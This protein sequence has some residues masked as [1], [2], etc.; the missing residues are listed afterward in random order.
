MLRQ[1]FQ[2]VLVITFDL[3]LC[4][5]LLLPFAAFLGIIAVRAIDPS[6]VDVADLP[7]DITGFRLFAQ[8]L[9][10]PN[11]MR[12]PLVFNFLHIGPFLEDCT[13][14]LTASLLPSSSPENTTRFHAENSLPSV[15]PPSRH[16]SPLPFLLGLF[17]AR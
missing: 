12:F 3:V 11:A 13:V 8:S 14:D 17:P 4:V 15:P 5:C 16:T 7:A 9:A 1:R 10:A 6:I 2:E